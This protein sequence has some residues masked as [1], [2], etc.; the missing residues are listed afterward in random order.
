MAPLLNGGLVAAF[1]AGCL[2]ADGIG[3]AEPD[4]VGSV[5]L[6]LSAVLRD[7]LMQRMFFGCLAVYFPVFYFLRRRTEVRFNSHRTSGANSPWPVRS[8]R[9]HARVLWLAGA[10]GSGAI[11]YAIDG[12]PSLASLTLLGGAVIGQCFALWSG[13]SARYSLSTHG[14]LL[15]A[16]LALAAMW[17]VDPSRSFIYQAQERWTGPWDNPNLFGVLMGTGMV[18]SIGMA[19][20]QMQAAEKGGKGVAFGGNPA[21]FGRYGATLLCVLAAVL[22]GRGLLHSF[23]RGAWLGTVAGIG[24]LV[25]QTARQKQKLGK[26]KSEMGVCNV[27]FWESASLCSLRSVRLNFNWVSWS[28]VLLS[29]IVLFL[30]QVRGTDWH[31]VRRALSVTKTEDFSWRNRVAAWE[32]ALQITAEHPWFGTG[33]NQ[34]E[35]LYEHYYLPTKLNES[36]AIQM[37]DYLNLGATLGFPALFCFGMYLWLT[38]GRN[39]ESGPA[40]REGKRETAGGQAE[41][42]S[43]FII[44]PSSFLQTT[45]HAGAIVLLVGFWFDGGLFKLPT[46]ATF[47]ILLELGA[48]LPRNSFTASAAAKAKADRKNAENAKKDAGIPT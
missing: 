11:L 46:A 1:L 41:L 28:V 43:Y 40:A 15:I 5:V 7:S 34:P 22:M 18:L 9:R 30:W 31:P 35:S 6:E 21:E 44:H 27:E 17:N 29:V 47:W 38:L 19:E 42:P 45:C 2:L 4:Y 37:N 25:F 33:W 39:A 8:L 26:L 14:F 3:R 24:Y 13:L 36:R 12:S 23:S 48:A 20:S 32:G 10:L 16:L